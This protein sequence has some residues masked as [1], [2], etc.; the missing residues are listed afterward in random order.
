MN[1][2][3]EV[4]SRSTLSSA[5][6]AA[7]ALRAGGV[8]GAVRENEVQGLLEIYRMRLDHLKSEPGPLAAKLASEMVEMLENLRGATSVQ[9]TYVEGPGALLF[10]IFLTDSGSRVLGCCSGFD[11]RKVS[12]E[13]WEELWRGAV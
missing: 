1:D 3:A 12:D 2:I 5:Q 7:E 8:L 10:Y 11:K 9:T 6:E 13:Q 4:L